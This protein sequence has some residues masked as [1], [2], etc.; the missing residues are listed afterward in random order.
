MN[1]VTSGGGTCHPDYR[2]D[3]GVIALLDERF[4]QKVIIRQA[5]PQESGNERNDVPA[6][7]IW[8]K[9]WLASGRK[10]IYN[11]GSRFKNSSAEAP[12][13]G[14]VGCVR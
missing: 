6:I 10:C 13:I 5:V 4:L 7:V 11:V 9:S 14:R 12:R 1:K 2:S 3:V 8:T